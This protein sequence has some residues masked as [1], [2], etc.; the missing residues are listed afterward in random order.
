MTI[1]NNQLASEL[2]SDSELDAS[3]AE[4]RAGLKKIDIEMALKVNAR[5]KS[6]CVIIPKLDSPTKEEMLARINLLSDEI[7][8]NEE[9]NRF[10]QTEIDGLYARID[11]LK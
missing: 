11:A 10:M 1:I 9:E 6:S 8:A 4:F 2:K 3:Q 7:D 5:I